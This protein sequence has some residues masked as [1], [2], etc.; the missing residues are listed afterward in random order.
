MFELLDL[1]F[2]AQ[3]KI[4]LVLAIFSLKLVLAGAVLTVVLSELSIM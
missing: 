2:Y 1:W 4:V 3:R